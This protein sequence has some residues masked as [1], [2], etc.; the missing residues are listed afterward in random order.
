MLGIWS[1]VC[2]VVTRQDRCKVISASVTYT[3]MKLICYTGVMGDVAGWKPT[4]TLK[5]SDLR[6]FCD[7]DKRWKAIQ[8]GLYRDE[9]K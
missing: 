7:N 1:K 8:A 9:A 5:T 2:D 6:I 3:A 4:S